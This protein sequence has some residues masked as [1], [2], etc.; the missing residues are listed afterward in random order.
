MIKY[1]PT[2]IPVNLPATIAS[3][4]IA[5]QGTNNANC[6]KNHAAVTVS[7]ERLIKELIP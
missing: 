7:K 6:L 1:F 4:N 2:A 5:S 3:K